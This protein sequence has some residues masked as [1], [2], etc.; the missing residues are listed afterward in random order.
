MSSYLSS[1]ANGESVRQIYNDLNLELHEECLGKLLKVG[2][3]EPLAKYFGQMFVR[4]GLNFELLLF[5]CLYGEGRPRLDLEYPV[6]GAQ[7]LTDEGAFTSVVVLT[8]SFPSG[9]LF[10]SGWTYGILVKKRTNN[11]GSF[12]LMPL[13]NSMTR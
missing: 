3:D 10:L 9:L 11:H 5:V 7:K 1:E 12:R 13:E 8:T 6:Y 2:M 4:S